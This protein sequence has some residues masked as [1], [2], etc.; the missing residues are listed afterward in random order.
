MVMPATTASP[1]PYVRGF[2]SGSETG[3]D[4]TGIYPIGEPSLFA[5][6]KNLTEP[7]PPLEEVLAGTSI[8]ENG[9]EAHARSAPALE[10]LPRPRRLETEYEPHLR[11]RAIV[12]LLSLFRNF[13]D[14]LGGPAAATRAA[15]LRASLTEIYHETALR[16]DSRNFATAVSMLQDLLRP[17]WSKV[18]VSE[19]EAVCDYLE[20]LDSA[21]ELGPSPIA[22][23]YEQVSATLGTGISL[24]LEEEDGATLE[25]GD[26]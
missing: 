14:S 22:R 16:A 5:L 6:T 4:R 19:V 11:Y 15:E 23:F 1:A 12:R 8:V 18:P 24:D 26:A 13:K 25:G 7:M 17:H 9:S 20:R 21:P 3:R 2:S 10:V